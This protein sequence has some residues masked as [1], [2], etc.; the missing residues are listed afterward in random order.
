MRKSLVLV[1][2]LALLLASVVRAQDAVAIEIGDTVSGNLT[3]EA[4]TDIYTFEAEVGQ[5]ITITL[6]SDDEENSFDTFLTLQDAEGNVLAT[7]DDS[8]GNLDSQ[9]TGFSIESAGTYQI[10]VQSYESAQ[11][12]VGE[13]G[14]Y[15]LTV[16]EAQ[17]I[18]LEYGM[19]VEG[20]LSEAETAVYYT[21]R[22]DEGD[23]IL[24]TMIAADGWD[25]YL[26]L[27]QGTEDSTRLGSDDDS[28]G[29]FNSLIGPFTL[30]ASGLYTIEATSYGQASGSASAADDFANGARAFTL[31]LQRAEVVTLA[32]GDAIEGT[33]TQA[34]QFLYY[35]FEGESGQIIDVNIEGGATIGTSVV[36]NSPEGFQIAYSDSYSGA[37]P[38]VN[39]IQINQTGTYTILI[40]TLEG[41]STGKVTISIDEAILLSL[42]EGSQTVNF[43]NIITRNSV[44]FTGNDG[45]QVTLIIRAEE[46]MI[47]S[48][49][50]SV[51]QGAL[52]LSYIS[53]STVSSLEATF[54]VPADGVVLVQIDE[55]SYAYNALEVTLERSE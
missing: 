54:I 52:T 50:I 49:S 27:Y 33:F 4:D 7:D 11:G 8:A 31:T 25:T 14:D 26:N 45:E 30:P 24:V 2:M 46:G 47:A 20:E 23:T 22:G 53:A 48:P 37:D 16:E 40:R 34:Q 10:L 13:A 35:Q 17:G 44:V 41:G 9:V 1:L 32:Y 6:I 38:S 36:L 39:D 15:V 28:A 3:V 29:N 55:F 12:N 42:D 21:F 51:S 18:I 5:I 43:S 19:S